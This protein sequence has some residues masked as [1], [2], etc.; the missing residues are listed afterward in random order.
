MASTRSRTL[1]L[2]PSVSTLA[3][4]KQ[5]Q[6]VCA[7]CSEYI[8]SASYVV[9]SG[10]NL[11]VHCKKKCSGYTSSEIQRNEIINTFVCNSC[12]RKA[13]DEDVMLVEETDVN[14]GACMKLLSRIFKELIS[15]REE[16]SDLKRDNQEL[17]RQNAVI[18]TT[19]NNFTSK[20]SISNNKVN[21]QNVIRGRSPRRPSREG[22]QNRSNSSSRKDRRKSPGDG[23][24][25]NFDSLH[26]SQSKPS[27]RRHAYNNTRNL[28]SNVRIVHDANV[29]LTKR[30]QIL[31]SLPVSRIK[32]CNKNIFVSLKNS[33]A[34]SEIVHN[35]LR[36]NG[37]NVIRVTR[38]RSK[39][40]YYRC[41]VITCTDLD[42][43][44]VVNPDLWH[45]NSVVKEFNG[46]ILSD[47][48]IDCYPKEL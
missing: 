44:D 35:H 3:E 15:C 24:R 45:E 2:S 23:R 10:C 42:H 33:E 9:C 41:F 32:I 19:L 4:K 17:R 7:N 48:T 26:G 40:D 30:S 38:I 20:M 39:Y 18:L 29:D 25:V 16:M 37:V 28:N 47:K 14:N 21:S 31:S 46:N 36:K 11:E 12:S 43:N 8:N 13:E 1:E 22:S 34:N 6:S 27:A 5:K